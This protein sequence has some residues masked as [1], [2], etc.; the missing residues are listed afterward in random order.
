[1][2]RYVSGDPYIG[3]RGSEKPRGFAMEATFDER[4]L[5]EL[6]PIEGYLANMRLKQ[7][8]PRDAA[9]PVCLYDRWGDIVHQW[10]DDYMPTRDEVRCVIVG[11]NV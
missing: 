3:P 4:P 9:D 2:N 11:L 6:L 8:T 10:P 1:M 7:M 5:S